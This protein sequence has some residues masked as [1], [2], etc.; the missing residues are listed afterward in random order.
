MMDYSGIIQKISDRYN[1]G[2][3]RLVESR[4]FSGVNSW[5]K[6]VV[7]YIRLA[8]NE[9]DA[10]F[11]QRIL[12]AG[13]AVKNA[14]SARQTNVEYE[15]QGS[16]MTQTHIR[17]ASDIDLLTISAKF[18]NT[19]IDR[20]R[21]ELQDTR[22]YSYSEVQG[23]QRYSNSFSLYTGDFL[24]D[25]RAL[26]DDD[27]RILTN[28]Y[29]HVDITKPKSI[30]V[31]PTQYDVDVDVVVAAWFDSFDFARYG[32]NK[33]Y[34]GIGIYNKE[35]DWRENPSFPFLSIERINRRSSD[36][37]GR[38]KKMI[39]FLKNVKEDLGTNINLTSFEINAICYDIPQHKYENVTYLD[40]VYI[41]W[42]KLYHIANNRSMAMQL[43]SVDGTEYVFVKNPD[44]YD[45][46]S[47]LEDLVWGIYQQ[48]K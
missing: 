11:T 40:L 30:K 17:A 42:D 12:N 29:S 1:P 23:L 31:H 10:S 39:R 41:L 4:M 20:V 24:Q 14:L 43:K 2:R 25:L 26:R 36:T 15:F 32:Q 13:N 46:V 3:E 9:V 18:S 44:R 22:Q 21:R 6:D 45:S 37:Q 34:R 27:E 35:K 16:V 47:K 33:V 28:V 5:D 19:E 48:L 8:M 38:L 7:K